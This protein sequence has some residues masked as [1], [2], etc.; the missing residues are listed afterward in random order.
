MN[1][2]DDITVSAGASAAERSVRE[3]AHGPRPL[4]IYVHVPFC[5]SRCTFC[6]WVEGIPIKDLLRKPEDS[7]RAQYITALCR[8]IEHWGD[9][10]SGGGHAPCTLFWGGGTASS[11]TESEATAVMSALRDSFDLDGLAEATIECSPDSLPPGKLEFFRS[12]GF[13]RMTSGVQ[14]FVD[15][16]L[17]RLGR[18][19]TADEARAVVMRAREA[20]F[21]DVSIDIMSGFPDQTPE[22]IAYT[23]SEALKLP[24]NQ[25]ALYSFRPTQGTAM[26]LGMERSQSDAEHR[27]TRAYLRSQQMLFGAARQMIRNSG[28]QEYASGYFGDVS[29]FSARTFQLTA[30]VIGFGSGAVSLLDQRFRSHLKG[31]LHAYIADPLQCELSMPA[32]NDRVLLQLMQIGLSMFDGVLRVEWERATGASLEEVLTR[33]PI[34]PLIEFL[35][36]RGLV[37]DER[38][39]RLPERQAY[40]TL[41]ELALEM[42]LA[43]PAVKQQAPQVASARAT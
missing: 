33:P 3:P 35:R 9:R 41:I 38:G 25:L 14:S 39:I 20:G 29:P 32:D 22:E 19:H 23:T 8:E 11:L 1:L 36:R 37:E 28:M 42:A 34:A 5:S 10:L 30:E 31:L 21:S 24:V 2:V 13:D 17:R 7:V 43:E 6:D 12:L 27:D 15:E 4:M 18:Q 16:R 26:R 40:R